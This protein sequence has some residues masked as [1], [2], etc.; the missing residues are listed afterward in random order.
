MYSKPFG[1]IF[2][3]DVKQPAK[4]EP[5]PGFLTADDSPKT[6][7]T[8]KAAPQQSKP[9][10]PADPAKDAM[11]ARQQALKRASVINPGDG[12]KLSLDKDIVSES[13]E[14]ELA[15]ATHEQDKSKLA[16]GQVIR[17]I[18][19]LQKDIK[20]A[21][22]YKTVL[23]QYSDL[24]EEEKEK[25]D[26]W[27]IKHHKAV[28]N[29]G[30][31][32][33]LLR[34]TKLLKEKI[35]TLDV[36][37]KHWDRLKSLKKKGKLKTASKLSKVKDIFKRQKAKDV[38]KFDSPGASEHAK[39][40]AKAGREGLKDLKKHDLGEAYG[41][42][43]ALRPLVNTAVVTR[44]PT[45]MEPKKYTPL[46][47]KSLYSMPANEKEAIMHVLKPDP[48]HMIVPADP[49]KKAAR[50]WG[51][52]KQREWKLRQS[53]ED[54]KTLQ[55]IYKEHLAE[56]KG[57]ISKIIDQDGEKGEA[58]TAALGAL[59]EG[60]PEEFLKSADL[61][62]ALKNAFKTTNQPQL[63][64]LGE[65][66]TTVDPE[67]EA[68]ALLEQATVAHQTAKQELQARE[69][70]LKVAQAEVKDLPPPPPPPPINIQ[71]TVEP[72]SANININHILLAAV[73]I[74]ALTQVIK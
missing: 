5:K 62:R 46:P 25:V 74:W 52:A 61:H 20:R 19:A 39:K 13:P 53:R 14:L 3:D 51:D 42:P 31:A 27:L 47:K 12:A 6:V 17:A 40:I 16:H 72:K 50:R 7:V 43:G 26:K 32:R 54:L 37:I 36:D 15:E 9:L 29:F 68:K 63:E 57:L 59:T 73:A 24:S 45:P 49:K 34:A 18:K 67:K 56:I 2:G 64:G 35:A 30:R 65:E 58:I 33:K 48:M 41:V 1:S 4:A 69:Y 8:E 21:E 11:A 44:P 55:N 10:A 28:K 23:L 70:A 22:V 66:V 71:V 38:P 60:S